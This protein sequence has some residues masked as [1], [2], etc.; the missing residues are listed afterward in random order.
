MSPIFEICY[1]D[2]ALGDPLINDDHAINVL[3]IINK[4]QLQEIKSYSLKINQILQKIF[5][6]IKIKMKN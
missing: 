2:D 3:K 4:N 5:K 6:D 1:K